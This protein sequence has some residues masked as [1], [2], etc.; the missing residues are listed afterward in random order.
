ML[1][2]GA[3]LAMVGS[4]DGATFWS[5]QGTFTDSAKTKMAID[6]SPKGGPAD[7]ASEHTPGKLTFPDGNSWGQVGGG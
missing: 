1:S 3:A 4:D 5:L 7:L 6:F 2:A